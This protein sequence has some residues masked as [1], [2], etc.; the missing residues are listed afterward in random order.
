MKLLE[1]RRLTGPNLLLDR[2]GAVIEVALEPEEAAAAVAAWREHA[3]RILDAVGWPGEETAARLFSGGASLAISAPIDALYAAT[4]VNEWAWAAAEASFRGEVPDIAAGRDALLRLIA[5]EVNP[6]LLAL[7]DAA[8]ARGVAFLSDGRFAS[9]GL[10][11][12]SLTWPV[13]ELPPPE[14]IDWSAVHDVPVLLVTGTNGKSTTV[15]LVAA[16]VTAAGKVPGLTSTDYIEV[17]GEVIERGDFS[18]PEG[19]RAVLRDKRV[20]VAVLETARGGILR[21]GLVAN[22]ADAAAVTNIAEDHLGDY[23]IHDLA[24]LT[25]AKLVIARVVRPDGRVVLNA[26]DPELVA[27][28][29]GV[30]APIVW[31]AF[32]A[33]NPVVAGHVAAGGEAVVVDDGALILDRGGERTAVIRAGEVPVT[34]GGAA[35]Y[36]VANALAAIGVASVLR[37]PAE[38]MASGLRSLQSTPEDNPGRANLFNWNGSRIL[39][40]YAHNPHGIKALLDIARTLPARRKLIILGQAG[41]RSDEAIRDLARAAWELRPDYIVVKELPEMLRGR[42]LGEVPAVL[43]DELRRLGAPAAKIERADSELEAVRKALAWAQPGDLLVLLVHKH[44]E[45]VLR[46]IGTQARSTSPPSPL[47]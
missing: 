35:R 17:G 15:R 20:E 37:L 45:E 11:S 41:D 16:M 39:L 34:F 21:R 43:E 46:L 14:S 44:R 3:R 8:V 9:V 19:A 10:G 7:R 32:D 23:G 30:A 2:P 31:F 28:A 40:D 18:G 6:A 33:G 38:V 36:N 29:G 27:A 24:S 13:D 42:Q 26:D 4:E 12:G 47:S 22:R 25:A 1:S 5:Q